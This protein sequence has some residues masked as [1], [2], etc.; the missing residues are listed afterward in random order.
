MNAGLIQ[1]L[2]DKLQKRVRRL[3]A[4]SHSQFHGTLKQIWAFLHAQPILVG[5]T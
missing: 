5:I 1:N 4:V 2:R 3:N